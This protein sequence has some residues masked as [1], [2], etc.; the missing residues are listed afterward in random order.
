MNNADLGDLKEL[1]NS[2]SRWHDR[3]DPYAFV[4]RLAPKALRER[5]HGSD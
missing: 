5:R 3:E 2:R 1:L 4:G